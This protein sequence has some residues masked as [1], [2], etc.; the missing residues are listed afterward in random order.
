MLLMAIR[1]SDDSLQE[2]I[3]EVQSFPFLRLPAELRNRIYELATPEE[4]TWT[5]LKHVTLN[6]NG[7]C[8]FFGLAGVCKQVRTEYAPLLFSSKFRIRLVDLAAWVTTFYEANRGTMVKPLDLDVAIGIEDIQAERSWDKHS[9]SKAKAT[10]RGLRI[11]FSPIPLHGHIDCG[12]YNCIGAM[13]KALYSRF[14]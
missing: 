7:K 12:H 2:T 5:P 14:N 4:K 6:T 10:T 9:L 13:V 11:Q 3:I 8:V 1:A